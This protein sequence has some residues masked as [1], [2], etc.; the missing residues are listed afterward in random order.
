MYKVTYLTLY[1]TKTF[2]DEEETEVDLKTYS[3]TK[4]TKI[5]TLPF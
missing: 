4:T 2:G 3:T 5:K 1:L